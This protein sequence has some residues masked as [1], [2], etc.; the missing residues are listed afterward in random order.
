MVSRLIKE[1]KSFSKEKTV[2]NIIFP[3]EDYNNLLESKFN[4]VDIKFVKATVKSLNGNLN[5]VLG[6]PCNR[7]EIEYYLEGGSIS[8]INFLP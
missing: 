5:G 7:L 1:K 8:T 6:T 3:E 2:D 4:N